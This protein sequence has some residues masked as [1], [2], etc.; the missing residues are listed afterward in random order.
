M[1]FL[2]GRTFYESSF[3]VPI[4]NL[5]TCYGNFNSKRLGFM[6]NEELIE[7]YMNGNEQALETLCLNNRRFVA[8][9]ANKISPRPTEDMLQS[10]MIGLIEAAR[11]YNPEK[12][13]FLTIA[14]WYIRKAMYTCI[15]GTDASLDQLNEDTSITFVDETSEE[16][17]DDILM[18]KAVWDAVSRIEDPRQRLALRMGFGLNGCSHWN[19]TKLADVSGISRSSLRFSFARGQ[20]LLS[21]DPSLQQLQE[22]CR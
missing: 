8:F 10:G 6:N 17:Y 2:K 14:A 5:K 1:T 16:A 20:K 15:Q 7:S 18:R 13:K 11:H 4:L 3:L 9:V 19:I 22:E 21:K 12:G